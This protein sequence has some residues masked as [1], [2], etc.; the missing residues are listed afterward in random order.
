[1]DLHMTNIKKEKLDE[2]THFIQSHP[3]VYETYKRHYETDEVK[4]D[5]FQSYSIE[6]I[7]LFIS[8]WS[9]FMK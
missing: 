2:L 7:D 4:V 3:I 6:D 8:T 9:R 1:M 5:Y